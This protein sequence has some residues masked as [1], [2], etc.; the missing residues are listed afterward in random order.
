LLQRLSSICV[1]RFATSKKDPR[2]LQS[3]SGGAT[4]ALFKSMESAKQLENLVI[5]RL[6][7]ELRDGIAKA[8]ASGSGARDLDFRWQIESSSRSVAS[9]IAEGFGYFRPRQF[10]KYLRIARGS[11]M[12]TRS[13]INEGRGKY[14]TSA[15]ATTFFRLAIRIIAGTSSLIQYLDSCDPDLDLR[16]ERSEPVNKVQGS[17]GPGASRRRTPPPETS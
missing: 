15:D 1:A 3:V 13:H 7:C 10:A 5:W 9:N 14:F 16:P 4:H 6:A 8:L 12:E 2:V 11:A 17:R